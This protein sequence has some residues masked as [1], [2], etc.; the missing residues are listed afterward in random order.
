MLL[1]C[2]ENQVHNCKH[3]H[4]F[5]YR[6]KEIET[7]PDTLITTRTLFSLSNDF[8]TPTET[9]ATSSWNT[10]HTCRSRKLGHAQ[11]PQ[12]GHKY[13]RILCLGFVWDY[14]KLCGIFTGENTVPHWLPAK[15]FLSFFRNFSPHVNR[16]MAGWYT[17]LN[18]SLHVSSCLFFCI[19]YFIIFSAVIYYIFT[20]LGVWSGTG[21]FHSRRRGSGWGG[22]VLTKKLGGSLPLGHKNPH[23]VQDQE[24]LILRPC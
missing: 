9:T 8:C 19:F 12:R 16:W 24:N 11:R 23:P 14:Q 13:S 7:T 10:R 4:C 2:V 22:E 1:T 3:C 5:G 6:H 20:D 21:T 15:V 17:W 18:F